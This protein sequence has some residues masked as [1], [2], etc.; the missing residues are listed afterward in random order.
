M[1]NRWDS[2]R[3][4]HS[5]NLTENT[6]AGNIYC[7]DC[8]LEHC[9]NMIDYRAEWPTFS[10]KGTDREDRTRAGW[11]VNEIILG[12]CLSTTLM[13]ADASLNRLGR[14][15]DPN[16]KLRK[17]F[18][19]IEELCEKLNLTTTQVIHRACE[20]F[21]RVSTDG[22][23]KVARLQTLQAASVLYA[24]RIEGGHSNRTFKEVVLASSRSQKDIARC[25][26][27]VK[28]QL[29][30]IPNLRLKETEHP[31]VSFSRNYAA[32]LNLPQDWTNAIKDVAHKAHP[33]V[34][35]D[36]TS[37][38]SI[39][40]AWDG[41]SRASI[42]ATIVYIVT[43]LPRCPAKV[44]VKL[45]SRRSGVRE[46]TIIACFSDML[47]VIDKLLAEVSV[48]IATQEEIHKTFL[49]LSPI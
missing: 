41:R 20:V 47:P 44:D 35:E 48:K 18:K 9:S 2:C 8:G 4:C 12:E 14:T 40:K 49:K 11:P 10:E 46:R 22:L 33:D 30:S 1:V 45:I 16:Q 19:D 15:C 43:R 6:A 27:R 31:V 25:F 38:S 34:K 39:E 23:H 28:E 36:M 7:H 37:I 29:K 5:L 32:Y 3:V 26:N 13:K 24:A 42:A 21:K 17:S